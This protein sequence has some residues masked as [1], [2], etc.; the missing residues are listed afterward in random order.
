[1]MHVC[2][3]LYDPK[4]TYSQYLGVAICSLLENT[5]EKV[6]IHL[7]H[8]DTL[9]VD[10][11][12]KFKHLVQTYN[13]IIDF[14][15]IC[16]DSDMKKLTAVKV[17]TIGTLFR[18]KLVDILSS[19]IDKVIYLDA[20]IVINLDIK[21]L[22]DMP[23]EENYILA[24]K[25]IPW[26][27]NLCDL[28][29]L[30]EAT[31]ANMGVMVWNLKDIRDKYNFYHEVVQFFFK[32]PD[33]DFLDQ[34]AL[35]F[36]FKGRIGF[37]NS[38]FNTFTNKIRGEQD[39]SNRIIHFAGD[40]PLKNGNDI[41]DGIYW[42]YLL[43]TPWGAGSNVLF[44]YQIGYR[45]KEMQ[46]IWIRNILNRLDGR[47]K[48]FWGVS[49]KLHECVFPLFPIDI[50]KDMYVDSNKEIIGT[51]KDGLRIYSPDYLFNSM[52]KDLLIIVMVF[53]YSEIK[54]K[55]ETWNYHEGNDFID[56][57]MLLNEDEGGYRC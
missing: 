8:D 54:K 7:L 30:D 57:R 38:N 52:E 39:I 56:A 13:Q 44:E 29:V 47:K 10:N 50:H 25:D 51:I 2:F 1:M 49:G 9:S 14:H 16:M 45:K 43:K 15:L 26:K 5:R 21:N 32:Y 27:R 53:S 17:Y 41:V 6:I 34:D 33:C 4:G 42:K 3:P 35:N 20:D 11:M 55:L 12:N 37:L 24:C 18:L 36:L 28:G 22:W 19:D 46:I 40:W 48:V 23:F 31:Y